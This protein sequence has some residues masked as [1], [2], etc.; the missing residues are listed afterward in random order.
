M[1]SLSDLKALQSKADEAVSVEIKNPGTGEVV[2]T[3]QVLSSYSGKVREAQRKVAKLMQ[4]YAVDE[5]SAAKLDVEVFERAG[6]E[7]TAA[8]IAGWDLED[9]ANKKPFPL[10]PDNIA[11]VLE[12]PWVAAQITE[13]ANNAQLFFG[14]PS[15]D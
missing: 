13:A 1:A 5:K 3:A 2:F 10:T 12:V 11:A 15:S 6:L 4:K 7:I 8:S 14:K 9:E